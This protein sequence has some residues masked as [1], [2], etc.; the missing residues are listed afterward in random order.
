M[1]SEDQVFRG[2]GGGIAPVDG[3]GLAPARRAIFF[4]G[5]CPAPGC[6][7]GQHTT[8][9][10]PSASSRHLGDCSHHCIRHGC[11]SA[12]F[13]PSNSP[14]CVCSA[15][16]NGAANNASHATGMA[17][18]ASR[19]IVDLSSLPTCRGIIAPIRISIHRAVELKRPEQVRFFLCFVPVKAAGG[20]PHHRGRPL[21]DLQRAFPLLG[22]AMA[23]SS[24]SSIRSVVRPLASASLR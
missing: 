6:C 5:L 21:R 23:L 2:P 9:Y 14:G 1:F 3:S 18:S 12:A 11:A 22:A 19:K 13:S 4:Q 20:L 15:P 17:A 10:S 8:P 24:T 7:P 16:S